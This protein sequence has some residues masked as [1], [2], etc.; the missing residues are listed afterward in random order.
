M[1]SWELL[2]NIVPKINNILYTLKCAKRDLMLSSFN[3]EI[4]W[5][6]RNIHKVNSFTI[7]FNNKEYLTTEVWMSNKTSSN[8]RAW[9]KIRT[10]IYC[11]WESIILLESQW[12]DLVKQWSGLYMTQPSNLTFRYMLRN[13]AVV[14]REW[15]PHPGPV[16]LQ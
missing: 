3:N 15:R 7:C 6:N 9:R 4:K 12:E 2:Y 11:W 8:R 14:Q 5:H 13:A 10:P 16:L 1:S